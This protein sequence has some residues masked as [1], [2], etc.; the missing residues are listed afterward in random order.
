MIFVPRDPRNTRTMS[1]RGD[2]R[3]D[4]RDHHGRPGTRDGDRQHEEDAGAH[5]AHGGPDT[6]HRQMEGADRA[7]QVAGGPVCD[8]G[9]DDGPSTQHL[10]DGAVMGAS[11]VANLGDYEPAS[12]STLAN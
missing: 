6:E 5:G 12:A 10:L 3:D 11:C 9:S 2:A 4:E 8:G 1:P 7:F